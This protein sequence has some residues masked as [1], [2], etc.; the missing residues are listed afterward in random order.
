MNRAAVGE[1][2]PLEGDVVGD[3]M[4]HGGRH[5]VCTRRRRH[6]TRMGG[7]SNQRV[8]GHSAHTRP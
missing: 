1:E 6:V 5:C 7:N 2:G 4:M 8:T 3:S